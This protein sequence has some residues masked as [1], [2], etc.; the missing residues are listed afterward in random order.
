LPHAPQFAASLVSSTHAP[1]QRVAPVGQTLA[2]AAVW[3]PL[4]PSP[5][6]ASV[7]TTTSIDTVRSMVAT[8]S[9]GPASSAA[10]QRFP[11]MKSPSVQ[12]MRTSTHPALIAIPKVMEPSPSARTIFQWLI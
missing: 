10:T 12:P 4:T 6:S 7:G 5:R 3:S 1:A 8:T 9:V 2:S 11:S